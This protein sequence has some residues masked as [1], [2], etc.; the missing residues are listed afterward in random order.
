MRGSV[1]ARRWG[2][3]G[4]AVPPRRTAN[5]VRS[6]D[7]MAAR[8]LRAIDPNGFTLAH[9]RPQCT[10]VPHP[11]RSS[12]PPSAHGVAALRPLAGS[13]RQLPG[14]PLPACGRFRAPASCSCSPSLR[15][16]LPPMHSA[17]LSVGGP[18]AD[19]RQAG[20]QAGGTGRTQTENRKQ[21]QRQ[22]QPASDG[23]TRPTAERQRERVRMRRS[24]SLCFV[25]VTI[26]CARQNPLA[27]LHFLIARP[28]P[29][30]LPPPPLTLRLPPP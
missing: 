16:F 18:D 5:R 21:R 15:P 29:P 25:S 2:G 19:G 14:R 23:R 20:G 13:S 17:R 3:V 7:G 26:C 24:H 10:D 28:S 12:L 27:H 4:S 30:L 6:A 11:F 1:R 9:P 22:I 8:L